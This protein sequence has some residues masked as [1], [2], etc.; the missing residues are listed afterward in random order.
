M[1]DLNKSAGF[2]TQLR[3]T[4][5]KVR[6]NAYKYFQSSIAIS[7]SRTLTCCCEKTEREDKQS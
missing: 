6:K 3:A 2:L 4:V 1:H 7:H 5:G